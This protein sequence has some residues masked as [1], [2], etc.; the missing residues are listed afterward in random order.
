MTILNTQAAMN[1]ALLVDQYRHQRQAMEKYLN[2]H[3]S[4]AELEKALT[5]FYQRQGITDVTP[6]MIKAGIEA[7]EK[8][9]FTY[10]GVQGGWMAQKI[11]SLYLRAFKYRAIISVAAP[12]IVVIMVSAPIIGTVI[13]KSRVD[14]ELKAL[15]VEAEQFGRKN[16][17]VTVKAVQATQDAGTLLEALPIEK[18]Q[19]ANGLAMTMKQGVRHQIV[20]LSSLIASDTGSK[21]ELAK[22]DGSTETLEA[23]SARWLSYFNNRKTYMADIAKRT[24]ELESAG[25]NLESLVNADLDF[26]AMESSDLYRQYKQ[27]PDIITQRA[28][29]LLSI[30]SGQGKSAQDSIKKINDTLVL[31]DSS[32]AL[33]A[34]I[35]DVAPTLGAGFKDQAGTNRLNALIETARQ[36]ARSGNTKGF[37]QTLDK[38][39]SLQEYVS[40]DLRIRIVDRPGVESGFARNNDRTKRYYVVLEAIDSN[41]KVF[42]REVE[43]VET[44]A[45][46]VTNRWGQRVDQAVFEKVKSDKVADGVIDNPA[47]GSKPAGHY[48]IKYS[49][50]TL[51]SSVTRW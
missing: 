13:H 10:K 9:R 2:Q 36:D 33:L 38:I 45:I 51:G 23:E 4:R 29:T 22:P 26:Q 18:M 5:E 7:Y 28:G 46:S 20:E 16:A 1:V 49:T 11:A 35:D 48:E 42:N 12:A 24:G 37:N 6:E 8:N 27:E 39:K 31:K 14:A 50:P 17:D 41:G 34:M 30:K 40:A 43:N 25:K 44:N 47:F 19:H 21:F 3:E 15:T 32:K